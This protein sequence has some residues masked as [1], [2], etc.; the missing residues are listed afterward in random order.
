MSGEKSTQNRKW[1]KITVLLCVI[2]IMALLLQVG[3]LYDVNT[4]NVNKTSKVLLDQVISIIKKN[5]QNEKEMIESLKEDC[6]V[7]AKA[8]SYIIDANPEAQ[9]DQK[10][11]QKIAELMSIDEIHL[12]D[13]SGT[14]Y[15]G[16]VSK[17][18]GYNFDSGE[19]IAYFKPMLED[20]SLAMCQDVTPNTSEGKKMMYAITWNEAGNR[21]VQVG[22]EPVR[23]LKEVKQNEVP[24]VV[25]N[26]PVYEGISIYVADQKTGEI[27]GATDATKIGVTLDEL[28]IPT[29]EIGEKEL[30]KDNIAIDGEAENCIFQRSGDYIIGVTFTISSDN[31]SNLAVIL[32]LAVYL[33]LA[34]AVILFILSK[35]FKANREKN[36]QFAV[37]ASMSEIYHRM[38]LVDLETDSVIAYSSREKMEK[39]G[40]WNKNADDMMHRIMKETAI[41]AYREQAD[42]F[43]D[44]HTVAERMKGKK[45][46]SG[47]FVGRELGWFRASF[48][49]IEADLEKRPR[50]MIFTIQSIDSEKRKEEKLIHISNT[51][52][53][54]G[55]YNRRAY[56][57]DLADLSPTSDFIYL[58]M[59][60]NGLKIVNDSLGHGAGDEL[61]QGAASC[62]KKCFDSCG[63]VYRTGGDEFIAILFTDQEHFHKLMEEFEEAV[64]G[65]NGQQVERL[66][67]S[68]GFVSS[69][70]EKW[71]SM[72]EIIR[73]S[74]MRMY[75]EKAM[76]YR[77]NGVDR[78]SQP[79][80]Y[81]ALCKLYPRILKADLT[82]DS[83]RILNREE[84]KGQKKCLS[85]WLENFK[86]QEEIHPDDLAEFQKKTDLTYL[87]S[88]LDSHEKA[89]SVSYR[90]KN[91]ERSDLEIVPAEDY[92]EKKRMVFLYIKG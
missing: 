68:C 31:E 8:V 44:L 21:M 72:E 86:D 91:D 90:K 2:V 28:G 64:N 26:M 36:E 83:C 59:D 6:I 16:T 40:K 15:S 77:K 30:F 48:I 43:A 76:Y 20:K 81:I 11:L 54:T 22:I 50:K 57:R 55:C 74:D 5:Q 18:Y 7:R 70:E 10:E 75:E 89:V 58:S 42:L 12:F 37:P 38:Y 1:G 73:T 13:E 4:R 63:K 62:M 29:D 79:A 53:L 17:Y 82:E 24:A 49:M 80:A 52:T 66:A 56:E 46:I 41:E 39:M 14:I 78:R 25:G 84:E 88:Q 61:L 87:K 65:W 69:R 9:Y 33:A 92:S 67:I 47:E 27:Y 32:L 51:D 85:A 71:T 60:V 35:V 34:S 19:Q 3:I 45:I 23:L